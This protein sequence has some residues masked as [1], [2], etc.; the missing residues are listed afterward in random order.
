M[1]QIVRVDIFGKNA[2]VRPLAS[3]PLL[4][5]LFPPLTDLRTVDH[6]HQCKDTRSVPTLVTL[7]L[8][9]AK[10]A[11]SIFN[12]ALTIHRLPS[13]V[14]QTQTGMCSLRLYWLSGLT[15]PSIKPLGGQYGA[16]GMSLSRSRSGSQSQLRPARQGER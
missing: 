8:A 16:F 10:T 12:V 2:K 11:I 9:F 1:L 6:S 15:G 7:A 13:G 3:L 5:R 4:L 14:E